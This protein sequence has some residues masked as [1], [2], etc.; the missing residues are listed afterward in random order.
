M[1]KIGGIG[2]KL[3][4]PGSDRISVQQTLNYPTFKEVFLHYLR[5]IL[6]LHLTVEGPFWVYYNR[7]ALLAQA[8]TAGLDDLNLTGQA[9]GRN[10]LVK[11]FID[12]L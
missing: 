8:E 10:L 12:S 2:G 9:L 5:H 7:R 1:R 3:N 6:D 11:L 4:P